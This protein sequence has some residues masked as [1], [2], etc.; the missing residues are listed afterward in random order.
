[1]QYNAHIHYYEF[2]SILSSLISIT[3]WDVLLYVIFL[4]IVTFSF[5]GTDQFLTAARNLCLSLGKRV[6]THTKLRI[7]VEPL[8]FNL[9]A[10]QWSHGLKCAMFSTIRTLYSW[11]QIPLAYKFMSLFLLFVL[12]YVGRGVATGT[13]RVHGVLTTNYCNLQSVNPLILSGFVPDL[14]G[15]NNFNKFL[16]Y[17]VRTSTV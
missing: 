11:V 16:Q 15:G 1:M 3:F 9:C 17:L 8:Y 2:T 12:P 13:L 4:S 10:T 7:E 6:H 14:R 5:I